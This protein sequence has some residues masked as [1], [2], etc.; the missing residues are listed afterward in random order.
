MGLPLGLAHASGGERDDDGIIGEEGHDG[1]AAQLH[2]EL[3]FFLEVNLAL[4]LVDLE[5]VLD[6]RLVDVV[7]YGVF[8]LLHVEVELVGRAG[9]RVGVEV[10]EFFD[11]FLWLVFLE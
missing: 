11:Q 4:G 5:E 10:E 2:V 6:D 9:G 1:D 7:T 3:L 8:D